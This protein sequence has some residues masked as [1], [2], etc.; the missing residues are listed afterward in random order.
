MSALGLTQDQ[1][2]IFALQVYIPEDYEGPQ[3]A[4][5]LRT[6]IL[7][8]IP[9]PVVSDLTN[10]LRAQGSP[11]YTL[12]PSPYK[13]LAARVDP[14]FLITSVSANTIPGGGSSAANSGSSTSGASGDSSRTNAVIG[15]VSA[16]GGVT[17]ITL[18]FLV[19]RSIKKRRELMHQRLVEEPQAYPDRAGRDFDEDSVGGQRRRS[20]YFA[21][22]SLRGY[23]SVMTGG[24]L[25]SPFQSPATAGPPTAGPS[26]N[27]VEFSY[28]DHVDG[29]D[30][31]ER[32]PAAPISAPILQ[33][34]SM[35]W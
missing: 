31:H 17:L 28:F 22:D 14:S 4:D 13:D 8:Y 1:V 7:F 20:F 3:D 6:T 10:E 2:K 25:Q 15:V 32:R 9:D 11:F 24:G 29:Q 21:E 35:N 30:M 27:N 12:L 5:L 23:G 26:G 16:L 33:Q 18:S 34:S 19:Y